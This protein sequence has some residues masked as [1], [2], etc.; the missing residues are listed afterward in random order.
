MTRP[1][2]PETTRQRMHGKLH[3]I[4]NGNVWRGL[5]IAAPIAAVFWGVII[6]AA[7]WLAASWDDGKGQN[8]SRHPSPA[9]VSEAAAGTPDPIEAENGELLP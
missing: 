4:A 8:P 5:A 9:P 1:P 3:P 2:Q 6:G 7:F